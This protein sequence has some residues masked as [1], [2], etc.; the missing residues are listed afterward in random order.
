GRGDDPDWLVPLYVG[1]VNAAVRDR[2][3]EVTVG[4]HL[5]R[6]NYK[7]HWL[8]EG[9]YEAV[10]EAVFAGTDVD[11]LLLE[12]DSE[13]AGGFAPLRLVPED[14]QVVLGLVS[15]KTPQLESKDE[16]KRGIESA[17]RYVPV[18][19]LGLSPQCGFASTAAGNPLTEDDQKRKLALVVE[20][21]QEIWG[22]A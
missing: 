6:G 13:R 19:N 16:L 21:A 2:S 9:G 1:A 12:F 4:M 3:A 14:R 5:C 22:S 11:V 20:V 7:G 17:A 8:A 10:A 18:E 15:S